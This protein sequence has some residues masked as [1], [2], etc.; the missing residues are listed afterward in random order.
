VLVTVFY[1]PLS[2]C[3]RCVEHHIATHTHSST[4]RHT[5][6]YTSTNSHTHTHIHTHTH[7]HTSQ[8]VTGKEEGKRKTRGKTNGAFPLQE[9]VG[10]LILRAPTAGK[11]PAGSLAGLFPGEK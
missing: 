3:K 6:K 1:C 9:Q 8:S 7:T 2:L 10:H 5:H 11:Y 4:H